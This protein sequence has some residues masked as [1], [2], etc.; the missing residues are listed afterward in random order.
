[1]VVLYKDAKGNVIGTEWNF[2]TPKAGETISDYMYTP[3]DE[4]GDE[5]IDFASYEIYINGYM[6]DS[7]S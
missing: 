1:M 2:E 4:N 7:E 3:Y 5:H 6:Y